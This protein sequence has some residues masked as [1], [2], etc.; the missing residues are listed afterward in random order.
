MPTGAAALTESSL[1]SSASS[2]SS[3]GVDRGRPAGAMS[4]VLRLSFAVPLLLHVACMLWTWEA[5][6]AEVFLGVRAPF[7]FLWSVFQV[8]GLESVRLDRFLTFFH[9]PVCRGVLLT[10]FSALATRCAAPC[11]CREHVPRRAAH[12]SAVRSKAHNFVSGTIFLYSLGSFNPS[13]NAI[14]C[15]PRDYL[16]GAQSALKMAFSSLQRAVRR[17]MVSDRRQTLPVDA[18]IY[19]L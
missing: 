1:D 8:R 3:C 9:G 13:L 10:R 19:A 16:G 5:S 11:G 17:A 7:F 4:V 14:R 12:H 2:S 18:S 15:N 6:F